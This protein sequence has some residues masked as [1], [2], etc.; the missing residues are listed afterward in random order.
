[1]RRSFLL[2]ATLLISCSTSPVNPQE[3]QGITLDLPCVR[4]V[5]IKGHYRTESGQVLLVGGRYPGVLVTGVLDQD[6]IITVFCEKDPNKAC[7]NERVL[8]IPTCINVQIC[9]EIR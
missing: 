1:M 8:G 7:T 4:T 6:S 5:S 9:C 2:F 3:P